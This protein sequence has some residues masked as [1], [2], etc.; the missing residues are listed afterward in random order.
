MPPETE[1]PHLL[2]VDYGVYVMNLIVEV[3]T[4]PESVGVVIYLERAVQLECGCAVITE[5]L[6]V[7][8]PRN[9][10]LCEVVHVVGTSEVGVEDGCA[11]VCIFL[12]ELFSTAAALS[13][14]FPEEVVVLAEPEA[15]LKA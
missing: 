14:L 3:L 12:T 4:C 10:A 9:I 8:E 1:S 15:K 11:L 5:L 13:F 7:V 6:E 2:N